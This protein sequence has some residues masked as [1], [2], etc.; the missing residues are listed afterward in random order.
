MKELRLS[1]TEFSQIQTGTKS[2]LKL[3]KL[4]ITD[5][6]FYKGM[7]SPNVEPKLF[8]P[9]PKMWDSLFQSPK[10]HGMLKI[11]GSCKDEVERHLTKIQK[12][13]KHGTAIEDAF[14]NQPPTE[15]DSRVDGWTRPNDRGKEQ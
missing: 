2:K 15:T 11:A 4:N 7:A 3:N 10:I 8:D 6:S 12:A 13:L 9:P 14:Q 5:P 1:N